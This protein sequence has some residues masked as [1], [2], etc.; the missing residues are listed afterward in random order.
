MP[1][2]ELGSSSTLWHREHRVRKRVRNEKTQGN[3]DSYQN[4]E[5]AEKGICKHVKMKEM[6]IDGRA[7][8]IQKCMKTKS[9]QNRG[10]A[11]T[12]GVAGKR[13][14]ETGTLFGRTLTERYRI[15]SYLSSDKLKTVD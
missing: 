1:I 2:K 12:H 3:A 10:A 8:A 6:Q 4:K 5:V 7:G 15:R 13:R 11:D 9:E 14:G